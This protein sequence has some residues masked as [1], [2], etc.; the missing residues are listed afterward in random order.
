[1]PLSNVFFHPPKL[2]IKKNPLGEK[3]FVFEEKVTLESMLD[4]FLMEYKTTW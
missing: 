2:R 3:V 4:K 1:M